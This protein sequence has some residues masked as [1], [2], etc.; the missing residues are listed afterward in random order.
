M[1]I[2]NN[3]RNPKGI[4]TSLQFVGEIE[5]IQIDRT[6]LKGK[7]VRYLDNDGKIRIGKVKRVGRKWITV[8]VPLQKKGKR[9]ER[10][11]IIGQQ[12]RKTGIKQI[13]W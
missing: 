5:M 12:M 10:E 9:V 13:K 7:Y 2:E 8:K 1:Q 4:P 11:R 6:E 3:G